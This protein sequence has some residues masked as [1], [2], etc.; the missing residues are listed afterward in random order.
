MTVRRRTPE[1]RTAMSMHFVVKVNHK[2][3]LSPV[4]WLTPLQQSTVLFVESAARGK[5]ET[6]QPGRSASCACLALWLLVQPGFTAGSDASDI[7]RG[8]YQTLMYNMHYGP[9]LG[10]QGRYAQLAPAVPRVFHIPYMTQL[11]IGPAWAT[12]PEAQRQQV[13]QAFERYVTAVYA[14]RFDK[15]SGGCGPNTTLYGRRLP[16]GTLR[17]AWLPVAMALSF[18]AISTSLFRLGQS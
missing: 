2:V 13:M 3:V 9:S 15:Y 6:C 14:E 8:F 17:L 10:Q 5:Y 1:C 12:L 16:R 7:V 4:S 18:P 11:A